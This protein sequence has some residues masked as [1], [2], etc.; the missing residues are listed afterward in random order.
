MGR[1]ADQT[2]RHAA[3]DD[4][5]RVALA[6]SPA[7]RGVAPN[8][9]AAPVANAGNDQAFTVQFAGNVS[10][11]VATANP[12]AAPPSATGPLVVANGTTNPATIVVT[13]MSSTTAYPF[14]LQVTC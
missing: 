4:S 2:S 5:A 8:T 3:R 1:H 12:A 13:E 6:G 10:K 9:K 11:C 14:S 7:N